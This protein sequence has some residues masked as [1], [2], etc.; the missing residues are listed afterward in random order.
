MAQFR[1][2]PCWL[3]HFYNKNKN[4]IQRVY[5]ILLV[6]FEISLIKACA[7]VF[8]NKMAQGKLKVKSKIP[9]KA[10]KSGVSKAKNRNN[11]NAKKGKKI[12]A[13]KKQQQL[14]VAK[15]NKDIQKN[16]RRNIEA[17]LTQ[18][19][20]KIEEGR[21]FSCIGEPKSSKSK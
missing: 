18:K 15:F 13:P 10:K 7:V 8:W 9:Q 5:I 19:A 11:Q 14:Q 21:G 1:S 3:T 16:I 12:I 20:K 4:K 6:V 2:V 17:E